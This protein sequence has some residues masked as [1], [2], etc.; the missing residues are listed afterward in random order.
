MRLRP[1]GID[2][3]QDDCREMR[4]IRTRLRRETALARHKSLKTHAF[5]NRPLL[6]TACNRLKHLA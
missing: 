2:R 4:R 6:D 5:R 3:C 1:S